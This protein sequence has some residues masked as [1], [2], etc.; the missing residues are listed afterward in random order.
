MAQA[1]EIR[2]ETGP[3]D[4]DY[5]E[6]EVELCQE[7]LQN[8]KACS[9][10]K[11]KNEM[12]KYGG[13]RIV[14]FLGIVLSAKIPCFF[15]VFA[16]CMPS[17]GEKKAIVIGF[18]DKCNMYAAGMIAGYTSKL[19]GASPAEALDI[20]NKIAN[21]AAYRA[22]NQHAMD[23][24]GTEVIDHFFKQAWVS[25]FFVNML[26][27]LSLWIRQ[28]SDELELPTASFSAVAAVA[29]VRSLRRAVHCSQFS[30]LFT[31]RTRGGPDTRP[32]SGS[33]S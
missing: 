14:S 33:R 24:L 28:L 23:E 3:L 19:E 22:F 32:G 10:D 5:T 31:V 13:T 12:L 11:I 15:T 27:F 6:K 29:C 1:E 16:A 26:L 25:L 8:H 7:N 2:T 21:W 17:L 9:P 30:A 20:Q 4:Y 18:L